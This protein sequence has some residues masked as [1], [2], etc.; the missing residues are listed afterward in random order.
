MPAG[1]IEDWQV[2]CTCGTRDDDG[3]RMIA[4]DACQTWMHTRCQ[5]IPD[6]SPVPDTWV[7]FACT[8]RAKRQQQAQAAHAHY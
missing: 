6:E 1:G 8:K 4:C 5:G 7:C 3:E 2:H